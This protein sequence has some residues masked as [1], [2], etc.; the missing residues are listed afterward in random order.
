MTKIRILCVIAFLTALGCSSDEKKTEGQPAIKK[1]VK[2]VPSQARKDDQS[3]R[4]RMMVLPFLDVSESRPQSLRE[5]VQKEFIKELNN[6]GRVIVVDSKDLKLDLQK[7]IVQGDY[8]MKDIGKPAADLGA[9]IVLDGKIMDL[10][11]TRKA[12]PVGIFRQMK[13]KFEASVR[14]RMIIAKSGKEIFNTV[15]NVTLEE[16]QTRV[17]EQTTA[18]KLLQTNPELVERLI[19]DA[20]LDF[21]GQIYATLDKVAWEGRIAMI[22]GERIFL[23]VGRLSGLQV[24]DILKVTED[25]DEIFDPQTGN[26]IGKSQGRLKGTLEVVS[27]F[28]QDGAITIVHSGSGFKENDRVELY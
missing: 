17:G 2:D 12:D 21:Q 11:V 16:A 4:K 14:V 5:K 13:T 15:K 7:T 20:F 28:G 19:T 1:Q 25:G 24:G 3:P 6:S 22:N 9:S 27:Y 23:N 8:Q 26:F 10:K 18:D